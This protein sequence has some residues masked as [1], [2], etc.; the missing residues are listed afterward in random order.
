MW[1]ITESESF[2]MEQPL[3]LRMISHP[4]KRL[5]HAAGRYLLRWMDPSFP[6]D[7][8]VSDPSE[9]PFLPES[10]RQFSISH[11]EKYAAS[12]LSDSIPVGIDVECYSPKVM[13]VL[14]KFLTPGEQE[15]L[16][17]H[18]TVPFLLETLCWSTKEAIF[19]WH[20][21]GAV[22][23]REDIRI[24]AIVRKDAETYILS[25]QFREQPL[26]VYAKMF[27]EFCLTWVAAK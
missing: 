26:N 13:K 19:K 17:Q 14:H 5:Q 11:S 3:G 27:S 4:Q 10:E 21:K 16:L 7:Q 15:M 22:D 12:I 8:I 24:E 25:V 6:V 23:F 20:G 2:F 9:K 18:K 1:E